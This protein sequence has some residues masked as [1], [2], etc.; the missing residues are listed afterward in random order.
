MVP[1]VFREPRRPTSSSSKAAERRWN[2]A[3][4]YIIVFLLIGSNAINQISLRNDFTNYSKKT[5]AKIS[6]LREVLERVQRG[7]EVDVAR[8]LGTGDEKQEAE[9]EQGRYL[10][11]LVRA[12]VLV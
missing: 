11:M 3:T 7:E 12:G 9:W 4:V 10:Y 1:K 2:P 6:L 5:D 8:L